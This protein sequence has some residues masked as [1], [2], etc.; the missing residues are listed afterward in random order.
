MKKLVFNILFFINIIYSLLT[1]IGY[2]ILAF[3]FII[4]MIPQRIIDFLSSLIALPLISSVTSLFDWWYEK[5]G[6]WFGTLMLICTI[7]FF[8]T[9]AFRIFNMTDREKTITLLTLNGL[10]YIFIIVIPR[11]VSFIYNG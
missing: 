4:I 10:Q 8:L 5:V 1:G 9:M 7:L 11:F 2:Y 6:L 3:S